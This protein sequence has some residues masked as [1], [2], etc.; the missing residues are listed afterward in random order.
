MGPL[1]V[2]DLSG[3][4]IGYKARQGLTD[5]EKGDPKTFKIADTLV[6]MGRLEQKSGAGYYQYDP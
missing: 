2:G 3:L 4:D 6:E 1:A 5:R